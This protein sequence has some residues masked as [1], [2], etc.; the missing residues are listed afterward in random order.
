VSFE[1]AVLL[2]HIALVCA[3]TLQ[4]WDQHILRNR[5]SLMGLNEDLTRVL[6]AQ[7]HLNQ[8]LNILE[9]HQKAGVNPTGR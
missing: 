5:H 8:R 2:E 6:G 3:E 4:E 9:T 1:G 7:E